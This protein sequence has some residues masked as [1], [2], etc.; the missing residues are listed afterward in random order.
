MTP[1]NGL[2]YSGTVGW[3]ATVSFI[4]QDKTKERIFDATTTQTLAIIIIT[5]TMFMVL[6]SCLEH[7][8]SSPGSFDECSS[9]R[10]VA[11]DLWT[12]PTDLSHRPACRQLR[13]YIH[14]RHLLLLLSSKA[15]TRF[16]LP[17]RVEGWVDL[18]SY[19]EVKEIF[20]C[21]SSDHFIKTPLYQ[22]ISSIYTIIAHD[23]SYKNKKY[24]SVHLKHDWQSSVTKDDVIRHRFFSA[25]CIWILKW[26]RSSQLSAQHYRTMNMRMTYGH[27]EKGIKTSHRHYRISSAANMVSSRDRCDEKIWG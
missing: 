8:E 18:G 13:N 3:K 19:T 21:W 14:H 16:T 6:S 9:K 7:C 24:L 22:N 20:S 23:Y 26:I 17:W 10:H 5:R 12:K 2:T 1:L 27:C 11:A 4:K 15:D 25:D